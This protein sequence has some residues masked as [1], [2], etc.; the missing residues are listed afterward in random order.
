M[1]KDALHAS[2]GAN[3]PALRSDANRFWA[4]Q[5]T[6]AAAARVWVSETACDRNRNSRQP[7][8]NFPTCTVC[9]QI[10]YA[11]TYAFIFTLRCICKVAFVY[12]QCINTQFNLFIQSHFLG[13]LHCEAVFVVF[14]STHTWWCVHIFIATYRLMIMYTLFRCYFLVLQMFCW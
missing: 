14:S 5:S 6:G 11:S 10:T 3:I 12:I 4:F 8:L 2:S 7:K 13:L 1:R 9:L